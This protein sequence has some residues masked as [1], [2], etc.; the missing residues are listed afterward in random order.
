M[1]RVISLLVERQIPF[2]GVEIAQPALEDVFL[3]LTQ[4]EQGECI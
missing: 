4:K 1:E 3:R 2:Q